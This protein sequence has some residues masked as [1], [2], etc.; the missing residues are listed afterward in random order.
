MLPLHWLLKN[1]LMGSR[2][3]WVCDTCPGNMQKAADRFGG[4]CLLLGL[5]FLER[6]GDPQLRAGCHPHEAGSNSEG[7]WVG[8]IG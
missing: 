3:Q 5:H 4:G 1:Q 6:V 7:S 8:H 2:S